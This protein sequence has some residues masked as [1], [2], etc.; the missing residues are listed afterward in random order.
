MRPKFQIQHDPMRE[1]DRLRNN[2]SMEAINFAGIKSALA[3]FLPSVKENFERFSH[4]FTQRD[5]PITLKA[6]EREFIKLLN[7]KQYLDMSSYAVFVPEGLAVPYS[8]YI[9]VLKDA[10]DH[11]FHT[12]EKSL[13]EFSTFLAQI[14]TNRELKYYTAPLK[15]KHDAMEKART[16]LV[17]RLNNCFNQTNATTS[18]YADVVGRNAEWSN[19][20]SLLSVMSDTINKISHTA[21]HKKSEECNM[22]LSTIINQIRKGDYTDAGPEVT[23]NLAAGAYQ[24]ACEIEFFSSVYYR[25]MTFNTAIG[26]TVKKV[27]EQAQAK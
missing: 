20:F 11:C 14:I 23:N 24:V 19:I 9:E 4:Q 5:L 22:L 6:N 10:I 13:N 15:P 17:T 2:V 3:D 25:M 16:Q 12:T 26:D 27:T 18:T 1:L 8:T 21:L 7:T